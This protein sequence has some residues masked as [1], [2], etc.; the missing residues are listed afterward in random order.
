MEEVVPG[1]S[2]GC[3]SLLCMDSWQTLCA[4]FSPTCSG[5]TTC[6]QDCTCTQADPLAKGLGM[7][8]IVL[9]FEKG[10]TL[11]RTTTSVMDSNSRAY[12]YTY[13]YTCTRIS[14]T[15]SNFKCAYLSNGSSYRHK[16]KCNRKLTSCTLTQLEIGVVLKVGAFLIT[17][18]VCTYLT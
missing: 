14:N 5:E 13:L 12:M 6:V 8:T 16:P 9:G 1:S 18:D 2:R 17:I 10:P 3:G 11:C 4:N 7:S 15:I